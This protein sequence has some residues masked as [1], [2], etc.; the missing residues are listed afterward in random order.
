MLQFVSSDPSPDL[1]EED[2]TQEHGEGEGHAVIL[3][4]GAATPE[5]GNKEDDTAHDDQKHG[6]GEKLVSQE[7]EILGIGTL[8]NS[9]SDNQKQTRELIIK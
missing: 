1:H 5:E 7:V 9:S 2:D 6:G 4:D 3:L 8:N